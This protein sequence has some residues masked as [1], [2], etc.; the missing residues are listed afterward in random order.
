L[1]REWVLERIHTI[2]IWNRKTF[3][4]FDLLAAT[5]EMA[6]HEKTRTWNRGRRFVLA[7]I[8]GNQRRACLQ[9]WTLNLSQSP[10]S[11]QRKAKKLRELCELCERI[12]DVVSYFSYWWQVREMAC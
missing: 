5:P 4:V 1:I 9:P 3:F 8:S 10:R 6:G 7:A 2:W 11:T 12:G